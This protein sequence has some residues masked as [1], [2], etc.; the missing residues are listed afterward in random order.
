MFS[1]PN[2]KHKSQGD[3]TCKEEACRVKE[4]KKSPSVLFESPFSSRISKVAL[5]VSPLN[6]Q[7]I[8]LP[9]KRLRLPHD[10]FLQQE[11]ICKYASLKK[12]KQQK[13]LLSS[14]CSKLT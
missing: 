13:S 12:K 9:S 14:S 3:I 1:F 7:T 5:Q 4:R 10:S 6:R 11:R 8:G 2:H